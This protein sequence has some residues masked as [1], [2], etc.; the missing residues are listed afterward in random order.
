MF[1]RGRPYIANAVDRGNG[2]LIDQFL[3]DN[4]NTRTDRYGGSIEGRSRFPIE[5]IKAVSSAVGGDRTGIRLTPF[6]YWNGTHDSD[7]MQHW[8]HL[9]EK[10]IALPPEQRPVYV[11]SVEPRFDE[12]LSE[13]EKLK[14]LSQSNIAVRATE[15]R[16][17]A[18]E[19]VL[20]LTPF[21][22]ILQK[23]GIRFFI[24][25]NYNRDNALPAVE[26]DLADGIIF[27]RNFIANPDLPR[28]LA[29]GLPLNRWDRSTFY[30]A[31]PPSKGYTDYP[32]WSS[33]L[34]APV[35]ASVG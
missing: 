33:Q 4:I 29:E 26:R 16:H 27:G 3:H 28:R 34:S 10:I 31:D 12:I 30:S 19:P 15:I 6:N 35:V 20:S 23:G 1:L 17:A 21:R 22:H 8:A 13:E 2:Y 7:P 14:S 11:N 25:G 32:F 18:V 24:A 5:V 9:C